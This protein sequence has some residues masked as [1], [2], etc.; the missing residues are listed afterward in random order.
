MKGR[1]R[2]LS[3]SAAVLIVFGMLCLNFSYILTLYQR[4][5]P[6]SYIGGRLSRDQYIERC[7]PEYATLQFANTNLSPDARILGLFL[8]NRSYYS[9]RELVF[10]D[11]FFKHT[12]IREGSAREIADALKA[13]KITHILVH[14]RILKRWS[15]HN[16]S[17]QEMVKLKDFFK[18]HADLIFHKGKY[19]LYQL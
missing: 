13:Q 10:G 8:G 3:S 16:F 17:H 5:D 12:V 9:D 7:R 2:A 4:I 1:W 19:G 6:F 14:Y 15:G 11:R 18:N